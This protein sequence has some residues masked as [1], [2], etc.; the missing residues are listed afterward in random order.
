M[1]IWLKVCRWLDPRNSRKHTA[2]CI[3]PQY[4]KL[5]I[6]LSEAIR[7][8]IKKEWNMQTKKNFSKFAQDK[9]K[10]KLYIMPHLETDLDFR[11]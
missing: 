1:L 4:P 5:W 9:K 6:H 8:F 10:S 3:A 11:R 2:V 7:G